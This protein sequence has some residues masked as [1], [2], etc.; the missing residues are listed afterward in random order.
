MTSYMRDT[1]GNNI[2]IDVMKSQVCNAK[3]FCYIAP[4]VLN[5]VGKFTVVCEGFVISERHDAYYFIPNSFF[6][7]R[8]GRGEMKFK[9]YFPMNS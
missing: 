5:E 1:F 8:S 7:M 4:V 3:F 2:F 9:Q 6:K